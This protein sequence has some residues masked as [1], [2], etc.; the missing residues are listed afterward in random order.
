MVVP[1]RAPSIG[2]IDLLKN[3][4]FTKKELQKIYKYE[5]KTNAIPRPLSVK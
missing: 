4:L 3:D 5:S 1:I 2:Q